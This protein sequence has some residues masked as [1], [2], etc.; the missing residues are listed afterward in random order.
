MT[1]TAEAPCLN[2]QNAS[3]EMTRDGR[4]N[5]NRILYITFDGVMQ[6][7][8]R[9]QV[10]SYLFGLSER[11]RNFTLISLE[12]EDDLRNESQVRSIENELSRRGIRWLRY[13]FLSGGV[14]AVF[15]NC[16]VV[17][18]AAYRTSREDQIVLTHGRS[19]VPT[20]IGWILKRLKGIPYIFDMRGYWIDELADEGR[21]FHSRLA[22]KTGKL[23]E[24]TLLNQAAAIVTLTTLHA[25]D[26]RSGI[27]KE[28]PAKLITTITTCAD[29]DEFAP[30]GE[31]REAVPQEVREKLAGKLVV[32]LVGS[33]NTSYCIEESLSLFDSLLAIRPDSHLLCITRQLSLM[34]DLLQQQGIN[35]SSY[36]LVSVDHRD[37]SEWL[38][39]MDWALL[40]LNK[41]PSKRGSMPTKLA[42]FFSSG[43]RPI[44]YGC[45][46]EVSEKVREAGSGIV[47]DS[48]SPE[49]LRRAA[50]IVAAT[51]LKSE[52]ILNAREITRSHFGLDSGINKFATLFQQ[53][54]LEGDR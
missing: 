36:T 6:P 31:S 39:Y 7:L 52:D 38:R 5:N 34:A 12:R 43:V 45:N 41:R 1:T 22:Y 14:K 23:I 2:Y 4:P 11:G 32:G 40:L 26:L 25:S 17:L 20:F 18:S 29:Y 33:V 13:P 42:E 10:L 24:R 48:L 50:S 15:I 21:W 54:L 3:F 19:Y 28:Q 37:M 51:T 49:E 16:W 9:S 47:L 30:Q 53:L 44:Q 46:D 35:R 8:G 27:L